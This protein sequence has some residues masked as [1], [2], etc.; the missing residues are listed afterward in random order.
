MIRVGLDVPVTLVSGTLIDISSGFSEAALSNNNVYQFKDLYVGET[1][2]RNG[3]RTHEHIE[4][5][6]N[7]AIFKY[8]RENQLQ[9]TNDDIKIL[10]SGYSNKLNRKLAEALYITEL[11]PALNEQKKSYKLCLFN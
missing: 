5:D 9:A 6:K 3:E 8:C 4:T 11:K 7:F 10:D 1:G 2:V